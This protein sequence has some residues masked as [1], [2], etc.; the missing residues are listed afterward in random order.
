MGWRSKKDGTH[1]NTDKKVRDVS[2]DGNDVVIV[3]NVNID[4][5]ALEEFAKEKIESMEVDEPKVTAKLSDLA[6]IPYTVL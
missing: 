3:N 5:D 1:Y 4:E 2:D 6:K